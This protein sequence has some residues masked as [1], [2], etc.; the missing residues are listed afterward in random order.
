M[1]LYYKMLKTV[2]PASYNNDDDGKDPVASN[3]SS[4]SSN[5]SKSNAES[6]KY[7]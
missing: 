7:K 1:I 5:I 4:G 6:D 2:L 3:N